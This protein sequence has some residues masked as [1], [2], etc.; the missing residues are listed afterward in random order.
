MA[1]FKTNVI[2]WHK[3]SEFTGLLK[4][5]DRCAISQVV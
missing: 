2:F 3:A 1:G 4:T 5:Q